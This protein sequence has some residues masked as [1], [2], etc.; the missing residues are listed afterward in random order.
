[1][2]EVWV[3]EELPH[4]GRGGLWGAREK[5]TV[6]CRHGVALCHEE[7]GLY[8]VSVHAPHPQRHVFPCLLNEGLGGVCVW[9][10]VRWWRGL[11][12]GGGTSLMGESP[13]ARQPGWRRG[14]GS[15]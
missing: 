4:P 8:S 13:L 15:G 1:M 12:V 7:H 6:E 9:G 5:G 10:G 2:L 3:A 14:Q 11:S